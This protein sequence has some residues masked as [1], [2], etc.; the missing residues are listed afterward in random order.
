[1]N[2]TTASNNLGKVLIVIAILLWIV[3]FSAGQTPDP[4]RLKES[5]ERAKTAPVNLETGFWKPFGTATKISSGACFAGATTDLISTRQAL[6]RPG[7]HE[8][9]PIF[10]NSDG[11]LRTGRTVAVVYGMC[12]GSLIIEKK[13]PQ[14][15][16]LMSVMRFA[17]AGVH[18]FATVH[19]KRLK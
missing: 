13:W 10:A 19:N 17:S 14:L 9:N 15:S 8:A 6:S 11:S 5:I 1:M 18:I 16:K 2:L 4:V 3:H 7:F 12:G